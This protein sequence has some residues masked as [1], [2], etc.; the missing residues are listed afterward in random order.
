[1]KFIMVF[2]L[3]SQPDFI[4]PQR[5][6]GFHTKAECQAYGADLIHRMNLA[7]TG[8]SDVGFRCERHKTK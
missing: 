8:V 3:L 1:M 2:F 7:S 5:L 4:M 6:A